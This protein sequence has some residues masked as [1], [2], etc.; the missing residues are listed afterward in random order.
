VRRYTD[1][2]MLVMLEERDGYYAAGRTL[3]AADLVDSLGQ[4][5]IRNGKPS[6]LTRRAK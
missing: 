5:T 6:P 2:P 3:R 4:E 1:M